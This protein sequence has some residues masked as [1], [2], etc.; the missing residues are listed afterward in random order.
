MGTTFNRQYR[1]SRNRSAST[2][3]QQVA[4]AGRDHPGV[5][6]NRLRIA[7]AF[8]LLLLQ[9][10]Q[11]LDLQ[12]VRRGVD[13]V[14]EDRAGVRRLEPADAVIDRAGEGAANVPEQLAFQQALAERAAIDLDVRAGA[15]AA[16]AVDGGGDQFLAGARL[17]QQQHRGLAAGHA[18]GQAIDVLHGLAGPDDAGNRRAVF[19]QRCGTVGGHLD[20]PC[21]RPCRRHGRNGFDKTM[22]NAQR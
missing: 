6:A 18:P 2:S 8:K 16:E 15:A 21:S 5:D 14:Q 11:Q 19:I 9:H 1:S 13:L 7:D 22:K 10:A 12:V 17:A 20:S 4:V 3:A